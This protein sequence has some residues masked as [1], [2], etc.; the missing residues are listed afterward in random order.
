MVRNVHRSRRDAGPKIL[1]IAEELTM[2]STGS[3]AKWLAKIIIAA[4]VV[5]GLAAAVRSQPPSK[6]ITL[7]GNALGESFEDFKAKFPRAV[8]GS[9]LQIPEILHSFPDEVG[10]DVI[11]CCV[12]SPED[13][14]VFSSLRILSFG[15]CRVLAVFNHWQLNRIRYVIDALSIHELLPQYER[16]YGPIMLGRTIDFDGIHPKRAVVGWMR[17]D[18][19]LYLT[20]T[21]LV[22]E[23]SKS[24]PALSREWPE[25]SV[26]FVHF[27]KLAQPKTAAN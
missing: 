23:A 3:N 9:A 14:K 10:V 5:T 19:A 12:N 27:V 22:G 2:K 26:V 1:Y 20:E 6:S 15:S 8:C 13:L 21:T 25:K 17:G 18:D 4:A 16:E 7:G 24:D 11:G